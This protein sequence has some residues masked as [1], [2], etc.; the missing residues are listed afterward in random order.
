MVM[1]IVAIIIANYFPLFFHPGDKIFAVP[2]DL[3][4]SATD[5][6]ECLLQEKGLS[7]KAI[8]EYLGAE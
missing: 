2:W 8:G 6:A 1:D 5:V 3:G 7:K 4:Q